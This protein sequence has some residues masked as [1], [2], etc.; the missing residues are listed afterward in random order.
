MIPPHPALSPVYD[1]SITRVRSIAVPVLVLVHVAGWLLPS[2]VYGSSIMRVR[3]VTVPVLVLVHVAEWLLPSPVCDSSIM[4]VAVPVLV[5]VHV[6]ECWSKDR[7]TSPVRHV[8]EF[9]RSLLR[10]AHER[11]Q[12]GAGEPRVLQHV[13]EERLARG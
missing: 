1:S 6:A 12:Y 10:G 11:P 4:R 7:H 2:P 13:R 5:L 3:S 8:G 9:V